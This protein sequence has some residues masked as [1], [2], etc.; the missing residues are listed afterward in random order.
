MGVFALTFLVSGATGCGSSSAEIPDSAFEASLG[1]GSEHSGETASEGETPP[2]VPIEEE[3]MP[4][5]E[6]LCLCD[7]EDEAK[8][9]A[10]MYGIEL[11]EFSYGVA[12]FHAENPKDV[13]SMGEEKGFPPL[14]L[15]GMMHT[16]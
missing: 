12:T 14:E 16:Y 5:Q 1:N 15:N 11:V 4:G 2:P 7:T 3:I 8:E 10:E 13:I 9:I 6:L